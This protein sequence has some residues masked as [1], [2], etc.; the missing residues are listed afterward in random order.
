M[1]YS[2]IV[3]AFE[4]QFDHQR[5]LIRAHFNHPF[6]VVGGHRNAGCWLNLIDK[7]KP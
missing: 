1:G 5:P 6:L 4:G 2:G 3:G 7:V